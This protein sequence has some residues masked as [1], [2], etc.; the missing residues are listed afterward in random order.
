[1][2]LAPAATSIVS[3][4]CAVVA[5]GSA[6]FVA[7][8]DG[9]W[10]RSSGMARI[11]D[12]IDAAHK[13]AD[14]WHQTQ[15]ARDLRRM[16]DEHEEQIG[17]HGVKLNGLATKADVQA[18]ALEVARQ[19]EKITHTASGIDRIEGMLIKQALGNGK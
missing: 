16:L 15:Q 12:R 6:I 1:M 5:T 17:H 18:V 9:A 14:N 11:S 8:R 7:F 19:G 4:V 10:R 13:A 3:T 2:I